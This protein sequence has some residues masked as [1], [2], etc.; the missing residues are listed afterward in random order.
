MT[1]TQDAKQRTLPG[2]LRTSCD[3]VKEVVYERRSYRTFFLFPHEVRREIRCDR[4]VAVGRRCDEHRDARPVKE[5]PGE[6]RLRK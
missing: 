6:W 3:F 1:T 4:A 5:L 2:L